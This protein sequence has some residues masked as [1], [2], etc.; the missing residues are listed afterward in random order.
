MPENCYHLF[1]IVFVYFFSTFSFDVTDNDVL[2]AFYW[3]N[4]KKRNLQAVSFIMFGNLF[5]FIIYF[6][7]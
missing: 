3:G 4:E 1:E 7:R 2:K 5:C 6:I